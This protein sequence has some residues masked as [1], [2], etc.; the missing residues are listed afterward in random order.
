MGKRVGRS[1]GSLK[2]YT[3][4]DPQTNALAAATSP[5]TPMGQGQS[6]TINPRGRAIG[7]NPQQAIATTYN[8]DAEEDIS[9]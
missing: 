5:V 2:D 7:V 8:S 6:F 4:D 9:R 1:S 3:K